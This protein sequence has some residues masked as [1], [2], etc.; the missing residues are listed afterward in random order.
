MINLRH[1]KTSNYHD[2]PESSFC[3]MIKLP[4]LLCM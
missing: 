1:S 4:C 2:H 3:L